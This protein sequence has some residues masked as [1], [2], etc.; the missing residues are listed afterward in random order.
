MQ[1]SNRKFDV[2]VVGA[3]GS[4]MRCALQL[5]RAGLDVAVLS[6]VFPTRSM[7]TTTGIP[8]LSM[9]VDTAAVATPTR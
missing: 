1:V 3:G 4:G 8:T 2:V 6:K 9:L 7:V 5:A